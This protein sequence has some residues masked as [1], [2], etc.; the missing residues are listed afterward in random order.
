MMNIPRAG[1]GGPRKAVRLCG[2]KEEQ[3]QRYE[4][5]PIAKRSGD[6]EWS[7]VCSD[8]AEEEGFEPT[9]AF[10]STVFKTAAINRSAIPPR[11]HAKY[12]KAPIIL[13]RRA[14][15]KLV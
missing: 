14:V 3:T 4:T 7:A 9:D 12:S 5:S 11:L 8:V 1:R 6:G 2:E 15:F 10:A 13:S